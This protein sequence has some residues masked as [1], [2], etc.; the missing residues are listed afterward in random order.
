MANVI[1]RIYEKFCEKTL[2]IYI[3]FWSSLGYTFAPEKEAD[4]F[5]ITKD[6][7]EI[8]DLTK[9][10]DRGNLIKYLKHH[11]M[12]TD[13]EFHPMYF[14]DEPLIV[15]FKYQ[16]ETYQVCLKQL[17]SK[18][19]DH[20][21]SIKEPKILSAV[22]KLNEDDEGKCVTE[23]LVEFHGPNRNFF[24]HIPD[25]VSDFSVLLKDHKGE[26]HT[27]DMMGNKNILKL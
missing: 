17:E 20:S 5:I 2:T 1:S 24:S 16:N 25:T 23:Q 11:I 15:R 27:F 4:S 19:T 10:T 18:N 14:F 7:I 22:V 21:V 9:E 8:I 26:I 6:G 12:Y 3:Y 13:D